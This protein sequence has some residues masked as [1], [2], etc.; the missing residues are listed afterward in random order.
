MKRVLILLLSAVLMTAA[1][2]GCSSGEEDA[3]VSKTPFPEFS[4]LLTGE[5]C[6]AAFHT[7]Q[8]LF[9]RLLIK[10]FHHFC[11]LCLSIYQLYFLCNEG[12]SIKKRPLLHNNNAIKVSPFLCDTGCF[13]R[14]DDIT[15]ADYQRR[16]LP[17]I[18]FIIYQKPCGCQD[19]F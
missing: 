7:V 13:H 14:T 6:L 1:L 19:A 2:T 15:N 8:N 12:F 18:K 5:A 16:L 10:F 17:F 4:G 9:H 3:L 11:L